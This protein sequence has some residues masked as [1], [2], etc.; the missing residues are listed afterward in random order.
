MNATK[1]VLSISLLFLANIGTGVITY[2]STISSIKTDIALSKQQ[3][4]YFDS[5]LKKLESASPERVDDGIA[6][7]KSEIDSIKVDIK[8][9]I[10]LLR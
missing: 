2:F 6:V 5:R 4:E 9:M 8:E 1:I 3:A 7:V 10:K